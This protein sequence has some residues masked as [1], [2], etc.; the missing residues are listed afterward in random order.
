MSS[1]FF[2]SPLS[3]TRETPQITSRGASGHTTLARA[4][5]ALLSLNL[6]NSYMGNFN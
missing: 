2:R 5:L 3:E 4:A 1:L 6:K